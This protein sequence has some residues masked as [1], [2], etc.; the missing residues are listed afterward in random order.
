MNKW[1]ID[2]SMHY[3]LALLAGCVLIGLAGVIIGVTGMN[4][5]TKSPFSGAGAAISSVKERSLNAAAK[6]SV[7]FQERQ[8][9]TS[10]DL[11]N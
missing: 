7:S 5:P 11:D 3:P 10:I 9:K 8:D 2:P 6:A 1:E 4:G